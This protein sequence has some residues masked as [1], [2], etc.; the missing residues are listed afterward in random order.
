VKRQLTSTP[1]QPLVLMNDPQFVE[2]ARGLGERM[3]R[4]G[5]TTLEQRV[6]WAFREIAGRQATEQE[7]P[8]LNGLYADQQRLFAHDPENAGKLLK[9]GQ[10]PPDAKFSA[11][12]LAA[13]T[14][15][16]GALLNLDAAFMLR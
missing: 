10:H 11:T 8:V 15:T 9:V 14:T 3:L 1:L 6:A 7:L 13:A 4:D 12:E 5:G 2:A 16:A